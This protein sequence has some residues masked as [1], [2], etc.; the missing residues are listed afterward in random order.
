MEIITE[1]E[2]IHFILIPT[3]VERKNIQF[4]NL[5]EWQ[6]PAKYAVQLDTAR[7]M[8][9]IWHRERSKTIFHKTKISKLK[10][11]KKKST[12]SQLWC[13]RSCTRSRYIQPA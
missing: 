10:Q 6:L 9:V 13:T 8:G 12:T 11:H 5:P 2:R 1:R 7:K 4:S 3:V